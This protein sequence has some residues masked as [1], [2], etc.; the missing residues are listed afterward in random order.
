MMT[1]DLVK[2]SIDYIQ[3]HIDE[4]ISIEDVANHFHFSKYHFSRVF[5]AETG[6]SLY[7]FIKRLRMEQSAVRLKLE[8]D[9]F[10][11]DI[12]NDYGYSSSNYSSAFRKHHH[13]SPAEFRQ[14]S[15]QTS[16]PYPFSPD[17]LVSFQAF[18][19]YDKQIRIEEMDDFLVIYERHLG[20]Y[21]ELGK[22]WYEFTEKYKEYF[23]EDT[24]LIEKFYDDP[25]ITNVDQCLYDICITVDRQCPLENVMTIQGGKFAIYR[26]DGR[27]QDIFTAF[28]GVF[29]VWLVNSGYEMDERYG[30]NIYRNMDRESMRVSIELCIPIKSARIQK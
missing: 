20:N 30:F 11:T 16:V 9:K 13:I 21:L 23:Q 25:S 6:E 29:N 18:E 12:G 15:Q 14:S 3:Q 24:L 5:K 7:G 28:Q 27:V 10:I 17:N 22:N 26:F 1:S 2:K 19:E 8:K 4:T